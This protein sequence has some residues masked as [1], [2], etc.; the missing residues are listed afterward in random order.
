MPPVKTKGHPYASSPSF[1]RSMGELA[2]SPDF[3]KFVE[4]EFPSARDEA[5]EG[6]SRR[7]F[8]KVMGASMALAG[9]TGCRWPEEEI[10]P[11]SHR[12]DGFTPGVPER[13]ATTMDLHG[14]ATGLLVT[15][16]DGRPIKIEGNPDHWQSLGATN[17][18]HQASILELY[19]PERS[20]HV[21]HQGTGAKSWE[22]FGTFAQAHFRALAATGGRGL[23][24][25]AEPSSSPTR[26]AM[27]AR[28]LDAFPQA[29]WY[30]YSPVSRDNIREGSKL[31]QGTAHRTHLSLDRAL[32]IVSLDDDFL[33]HHPA[34]VRYA[35]DFAAGRDPHGDFSRLW[36]VE[37]GFSL[38]GSVADRRI[39]IAPSKIPAFAACLAAKL[40]LEEGVALPAGAES[41]RPTL[42]RARQLPA[43][44]EVDA[45]LTYDLAHH[46]GRSVVT[47]GPRQPA[48]VHALVHVINEA[49]GNVG[50]TV[51]YTLEP[52]ADR[53]SHRD[54]MF[55]LA[56]DAQNGQADTLIILGGN[57]LYDAP[58]DVDFAGVLDRV[59]TSVHLSLYEN[60]TSGA[61]TWHL[62]RAHF[63]ETWGDGRDYRGTVSVNQPLIQPLFD[64]RSDIELLA[65]ITGEHSIKG[66]DIV[67]RTF[68]ESAGSAAGEEGWAQTLH[69]GLRPG[70]EWSQTRA[71]LG[72][73][74]WAASLATLADETSGAVELICVEDSKVLDGR[75]ANSGWLQELP[76]T[77]TKLTWD[78]AALIAPE[79]AAELGVGQEQMI[80]LAAGDKSVEL[81]VFLL[82]GHAVGAISVALGYGRTAAGE[83][84]NGKGVDVYPL[85]N[86]AGWTEVQATKGSG[87][88]PLSTTQDHF[89]ID[90]LGSGERKKRA[91]T[92]VREAELSDFRHDPEHAL[93][94]HSH[95]LTQQFAEHEYNDNKWGMAID[96]NSCIGCNACVVACQAENN[97]PVVGKAEVAD[98]REMHWLRID[99]YFVGEQDDPAVAFQPVA[100]QHCENAPCEQVCPVAA[101]V[102][103]GDGLNVMV[104]NRC[105]GTR[106]CANNCPYKVRRFNYFNNNKD[107]D[108]LKQMAYNPEVTLRFR[109]VME[110]CSF[111]VQR[112]SA[113]KIEAKN[114][115]REIRD[116]EVT[117]A[118]AQV[119]PTRAI[120][121]G[122]L[123]D[124]SSEVAHRHHDERAYSML[125]ETNVRPRTRYLARLRN[126]GEHAGGEHEG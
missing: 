5:S 119:C 92:L 91:A 72:A 4:N 45:K 120:T 28:L 107:I 26:E 53:P 16:Y 62:P 19:D 124:E 97:I 13:Y 80:R 51:N 73:G 1:W 31:A 79:T 110:K 8:L 9:M 71:S 118:C 111:C 104:Y 47:A 116:G 99:R 42:E 38:T 40:F 46:R 84:G 68:F 66:Y 58:G 125:E 65:A 34:A 103:D 54:G 123:N 25:L 121:F 12:P 102:H 108:P 90:Q 30:E 36:I 59:G 39:A 44:A 95:E 61:C 74:A 14:A 115:R 57:P 87:S 49:L 82:P 112:I 83:V 27:R 32:T 35:R 122:D 70:T 63:L 55:E 50:Q 67:R 29:R 64:G 48:E 6:P 101:T 78:N 85:R 81:P 114:A 69:D 33:L 60:E 11:F 3:R 15:S 2:D 109:G 43:Y 126:R 18:W 96:L 52:D 105:V 17:S 77:L 86:G 93:H 56:A 22:E 89:A 98:G 20:Q 10:R 94:H 37:S 23:S 75:Y 117:P 88:Y 76:D 24:I 41:L 100:C 21:V 113:V 106:Y 7:G